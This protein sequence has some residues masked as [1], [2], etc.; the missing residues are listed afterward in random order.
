M[1]GASW[2]WIGFW[3]MVAG[4]AAITLLGRGASTEESANS[5]VIHALVPTIAAVFYLL[6]AVGQGSV[7]MAITGRTF[8]FGRYLDWTFT[9]P[10]LLLG[11]SFTALGTLRGR[12]AL[13]GGLLFSDVMMILTGVIAGAS[14]SGSPAKWIWFLISCGFFLAVYY[15]IWGPL[16]R[17]ARPE[18]RATFRRNAGILSVLW[19]LYPV[20]F[21]LG[22][23]GADIVAP[24]VVLAAFAVLDLLS[25][26]GYGLLAVAQ[27]RK[28]R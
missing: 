16:A 25:K 1:D 14:P 18:I 27:H 4:A 22:S 5:S 3:G 20:V 2:L 9:T 24:A 12:M 23:E 7:I 17:L 8:Y 15:L 19:F 6:M 10:L 28:A 11:L 13:V 21:Y 26:V